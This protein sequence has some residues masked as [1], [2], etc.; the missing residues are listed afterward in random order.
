MMSYIFDSMFI[1]NCSK[2]HFMGPMPHPVGYPSFSINNIFRKEL[3]MNC[4][5][6][7]Q[8]QVLW[9]PDDALRHE[10]SHRRPRLGEDAA[11]RHQ[12]LWRAQ[13]GRGRGQ[14]RIRIGSQGRL[15]RL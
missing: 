8:R 12:G 14:H 2:K 10:L 1:L 9:S 15:V 11:P 3:I 4:C 5:L 6:G 13:E 7:S